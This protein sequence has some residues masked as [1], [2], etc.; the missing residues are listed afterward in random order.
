MGKQKHWLMRQLPPIQEVS[1][2]IDRYYRMRLEALKSVDDHVE[3]L[4]T[5]LDSLG[6]LNRTVLMYTSDNGYQFGQHRLSMDK[7][8]LYE[9]DIRVPFVVRGPNIPK[10]TTSDK[11]V[12]N[13]DI[14]P[15]I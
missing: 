8:H 9:H 7:R 10:N 1:K 4:V 11:L 15:T 14:A 13:I 3:R 5:Q 2:D 6:A 12:A